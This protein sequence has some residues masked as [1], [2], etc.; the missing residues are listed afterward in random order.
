MKGV[1][2]VGN[3]ALANIDF[4]TVHAYPQSFGIPFSELGDYDNYTWINTYFIASRAALAKAAGK[5]IILE[6]FGA[7]PEGLSPPPES[8][9][10]TT[11]YGAG[12]V[13]SPRCAAFSAL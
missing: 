10:Y 9:T 12:V 8:S 13:Q 3:L 11:N 4:A 6:E 2:F 5:P 1:D 7:L